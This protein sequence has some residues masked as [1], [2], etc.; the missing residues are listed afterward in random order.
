M[1]TVSALR[2][3]I[4]PLW[5]NPPVIGEVSLQ[6]GSNT[7]LDDFFDANYNNLLNKQS[8]CRWFETP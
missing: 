7:G 8:S 4:G 6:M 2:G 3:V 1:E 5:G